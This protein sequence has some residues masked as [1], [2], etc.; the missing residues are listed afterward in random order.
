M[1]SAGLV[2]DTSAGHGRV[3][4]ISE[5]EASLY[6]AIQHGLPSG[7]LEVC[8]PRSC[9]LCDVVT[10]SRPFRDMQRGEGVVIVDAGGGTIDISTYQKPVGVKKFEEISAP[11]CT[12]R[13]PLSLDVCYVP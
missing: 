13:D 1:V 9:V 10:D 2:P 4:F 8:T 7:T 3:S 6:F 12:S 5:G 11:K